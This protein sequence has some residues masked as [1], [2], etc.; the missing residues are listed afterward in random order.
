MRAAIQHDPLF[1]LRHAREMLAHTFRGSTW[2][3]S[4]GLE[5]LEAAFDRY[6]AIRAREREYLDVPDPL[7]SVQPTYRALP[8]SV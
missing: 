1:V 8:D 6:C 5:P 4:L 7:A 2:R 3:S